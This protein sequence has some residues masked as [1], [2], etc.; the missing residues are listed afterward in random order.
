MKMFRRVL[1]AVMCT[2]FLTM[3]SIAGDTLFQE[4]FRDLSAWKDV[5]FPK[6]PIHTRYTARGSGKETFLQAES[7]ASASLLVYRKSFDPY[8]HPHVSWRW[9]ID[10]TLNREDLTS[11]A[12]DDAPLRIY[13]AFAYDP[14]SA[15]I[16]QR[17][18]YNTAK[19]IYGEYPPDSSLTYV[20]ASHEYKDKVIISP[21][22]SRSRIIVLEHGSGRADAWVDETVDIVADYRR[23][24]GRDPTARASIGIMSD[25]DNTK[26]SVQAYVTAIR[27]FK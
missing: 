3:P 1:P 6:I 17:I 12:G 24:F 22:T 21:Y 8:G 27:V 11:K 4:D 10:H 16:L 15:G 26:D 14:E 7:H 23:V 20:W 18:Q 19:L 5:F 2:I 25:T 13:I 9:K